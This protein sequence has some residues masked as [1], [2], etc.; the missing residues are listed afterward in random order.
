MEPSGCN[1][2]Q[3][4]ANGTAAKTAQINGIR[5]RGL[6][7]F[8]AEMPGKRGGRRFE[9]VRGLYKSP[10]KWRF[11]VAATCTI[12]T[13]RRVWSSLWSFRSDTQSVSTRLAEFRAKVAYRSF[14]PPSAPS[15]TV[16]PAFAPSRCSQRECASILCRSSAGRRTPQRCLHVRRTRGRPRCAPPQ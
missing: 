8:A 4:V 1:R 9:S 3:L 16:D 5:S 10:A 11:S 2:W 15:H 13:V 6:R 14:R 7:P 12:S